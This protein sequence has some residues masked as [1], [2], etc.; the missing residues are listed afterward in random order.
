MRDAITAKGVRAITARSISLGSTF[1]G[2][3]RL[4]ISAAS[5]S[6]PG[7]SVLLRRALSFSSKSSLFSTTGGSFFGAELLRFFTSGASAPFSLLSTSPCHTCWRRRNFSLRIRS[8]G[9]LTVRGIPVPRA[10][11]GGRIGSARVLC[12]LRDVSNPKLFL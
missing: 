7:L 12:A 10:P 3:L 8:R 2:Y 11:R 6:V 4:L 1:F 5:V 9:D